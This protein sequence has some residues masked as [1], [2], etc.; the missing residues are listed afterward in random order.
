MGI[1][2]L[3]AQLIDQLRDYTRKYQHNKYGNYITSGHRAYNNHQK[4]AYSKKALSR[5][6]GYGSTCQ[7]SCYT[8]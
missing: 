3:P 5:K 8:P 4:A 2:L 1:G 6:T 7:N